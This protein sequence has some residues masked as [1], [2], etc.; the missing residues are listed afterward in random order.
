MTI[1][2][3]KTK[4]E[5]RKRERKNFL[6]SFRHLVSFLDCFLLFPLHVVSAPFSFIFRFFSSVPPYMSCRRAKAIMSF[7][8][9]DDSIVPVG[10]LGLLITKSFVRGVTRASSSE[11]ARRRNKKKKETS[12]N[13]GKEETTCTA[14]REKD[15]K[16][17]KKKRTTQIWTTQ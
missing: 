16:K 14:G 11:R 12:T 5:K 17:E 6:F 9:R 8:Q 3:R 4:K 10:L 13:L 2:P 15:R 7:K 1:L